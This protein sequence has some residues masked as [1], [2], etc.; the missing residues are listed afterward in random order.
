L[1]KQNRL[2]L[3][4][5]QNKDENT[6]DQKEMSKTEHKACPLCGRTFEKSEK[7]KFSKATVDGINYAF[8]TIDCMSMFKRL[9][10]VYGQRLDDFLGNEQYISDPFWD[11]AIPKEEEIREIQQEEQKQ[12]MKEG[13]EIL[14]DP[15]KIQELGFELLRSAV[16]EI[17]LILSTSNAFHRQE[18]LGGLQLLKEVRE[19]NRM[20]RIR[21]LSPFDKEIEKIAAQLYHDLDIDLHD[22]H[23]S[24]RIKST[25]LIVDRKFV[26]YVELKDDTKDDSYKAM[27]LAAYSNSKSTVLSFV[28]IFESIWKQSQLIDTLFK[29]QEELRTQKET[30]KRLQD[31]LKELRTP[32]RPIL[33]L[34]ET[35]HSERKLNLRG[36]EDALFD[37]IVDNAKKLQQLTDS[38][39]ID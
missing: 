15:H 19:K 34:A 7:S 35:I 1:D 2:H 32:I 30:N 18:R 17:L 13:I 9:K 38:L 25:I 5:A 12:V 23:E 37:I 6:N 39:V 33:A 4:A 27:G 10:S 24:L 3:S 28:T 8:D 20:M 31:S 14:D 26:L 11:N 22:I 36:Q 21:L 29:M 16:N